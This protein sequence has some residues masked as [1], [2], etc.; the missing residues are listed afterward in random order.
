M[1]DQSNSRRGPRL[2]AIAATLVKLIWGI[3]Q[4]QSVVVLSLVS[5]CLTVIGTV[6]VLWM[7]RKRIPSVVAVSIALI[8]LCVPLTMTLKLACEAS[9]DTRRVAVLLGPG[10]SPGNI[11]IESKKAL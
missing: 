1:A 4:A 6:P 11:P 9:E 5:F 3:N 2:L 10:I 7:E 8:L